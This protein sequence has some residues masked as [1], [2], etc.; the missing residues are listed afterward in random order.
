MAQAT[1]DQEEKLAHIKALCETNLKYLC[2]E[3]L[4]MREWGELH[5]DITLQLRERGNRKLILVP[6]GHLKSSVV[7]IGYTIQS[8]LKDMDTRI[9][10]ANA[11]WDNARKFMWKIQEYLTEKSALP[12]L[13]GNFQSK[14]WNQ[15]EFVVSHRRKAHAEPTIATAGVEKAQASQHYD[16]I[17]LDDVVVRENMGTAEQ[18][19]KVINFYK[20]TLDL[21]EP[22]GTLTIIGTRWGLGELYSHI[23]NNESCSMN[24]FYFRNDKERKDWRDKA[25]RPY[26]AK[27]YDRRPNPTFGRFNVYTRAA[28]EDDKAIFPEKFSIGPE[29]GKEDLLQLKVSKGSFHFSSQQMND[30]VDDD[31]IEFKRK[32][33]QEY[34]RLPQ[35]GR[36]MMLV[37]PAFTLKQSND[38]TGIVVTRFTNENV[39]YVMEAIALKREPS[40]MVDEIFKLWGRFPNITRTK[41]ESNIAQVVLLTLLRNEMRKRNKFY[42]VEP[43]KSSTQ[44]NKVA[45]IRGL[46]PR[47]ESG[48]FKF[49]KGLTVMRDQLIEFPRGRHEDVIDALSQGLEDWD[50]PTQVAA[51]VQEVHNFE[52]LCKQIHRPALTRMGGS[53]YDITGRR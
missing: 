50:T 8:I 26:D 13:Y 15:D 32:Y 24:G 4:E 2:K 7:T 48:G 6:R 52:W 36:D 41:V 46:I 9:L 3:I 23:I 43:Y 40:E 30:P 49:A 5:D 47:Y 38:S 51:P 39:V 31:S 14:R 42:S 18:Q 27:G 45:K 12:L 10:I 1:K 19:D 53:F 34:E 33:Y 44:E 22:E 37:D 16:H 11:V 20:D 29:K 28:I 35:K 17:I 21:L 25:F